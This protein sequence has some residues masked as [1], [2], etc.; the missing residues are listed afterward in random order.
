MKSLSITVLVTI[1]LL[2]A[3]LIVV[4]KTPA[5]D[6]AADSYVL[7]VTA[8]QPAG[9][10]RVESALDRQEMA[11]A[12]TRDAVPDRPAGGDAEP[13]KIDDRLVTQTEP[14]R[15]RPRFGV[16]RDHAPRFEPKT[17]EQPPSPPSSPSERAWQERD[18]KTEVAAAPEPTPQ[19]RP[20]I[21]STEDLIAKLARETDEADRLARA[22]AGEKDLPLAPFTPAYAADAGKASSPLA[23]EGRLSE[24]ARQPRPDFAAVP[25]RQASP[26]PLERP[27]DA[28]SAHAEKE[29]PPAQGPAWQTVTVTRAEDPKPSASIGSRPGAEARQPTPPAPLPRAGASPQIPRART[30]AAATETRPSTSLTAGAEERNAA[31]TKTAVLGVSRLAVPETGS[32]LVSI[33][34]RDLGLDERDTYNAITNLGPNVTLAFSPYGRDAKGWAMK[35]RQDGHEVFLGIPM[36]PTVSLDAEMPN[37]LLASLPREENLKR[38]DWLIAQIGEFNGFINIMGGRLSQTPEAML[39]VMEA[40]K[41]RDLPYLDDGE[42]AH[43]IALLTAARL[44]MRYRVADESAKDLRGINDIPGLLARLEATARQKGSAIAILPPDT[45]TIR[46]VILWSSKL[47]QKG[48]KLVPASQIIGVATLP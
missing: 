20:G 17:A 28:S 4:Y 43:P 11:A 21:A 3:G 10:Q 44:K 29:A 42:A 6:I 30:A 14:P 18:A 24:P 41:A 39:A 25:E 45:E 33:I 38:L 9:S 34:I 35:A 5:P 27:A 36:E 47:Q 19:P 22:E 48:I 1:V 40:L 32:A 37:M 31:E 8:S 23:T 26:Q 12:V 13:K 2:A 16:S 15:Y 46:Q 7:R